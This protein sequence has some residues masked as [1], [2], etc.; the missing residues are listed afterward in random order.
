MPQAN[1]FLH[2][3]YSRSDPGDRA[4]YLSFEPGAPPLSPAWHEALRPL[5]KNLWDAGVRA[6]LLVYGSHLGADPF[7]SGRLDEVGGL[8]RGYSRGIPGLESLLAA[9]RPNDYQ[10]SQQDPACQPPYANDDAS[11]A[12]LDNLLND[13]GNFSEEYVKGLRDGL[14]QTHAMPFM[15]QRY[16]WSSLHHHPGR[17]EGALALCHE[18]N[19]LKAE[20]DLRANDRILIVAHGHAG[21]LPALLS[22]LVAPGDSSVRETVFETLAYFYEQQETPSAAVQHL[23]E[24]DRLLAENQLAAWPSLDVVTLGTPIRYGWDTDGLGKLLHVVNHRPIRQDGKRWL[25]KMELPQIVMEMPMASGGDYVHQLAVAGTD[26][27][28][29]S[30][31]EVELDQALR[32]NLEPYDGFERWLECARRVTR[33]PND[34]QCLLIDYHDAT[35]GAPDE[36]LFG[37]ACYTR[38]DALLFQTSRIVETL[39]GA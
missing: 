36:H 19:R 31:W 28:P 26:A 10:R 7:G 38:L 30:P 3:K 32:E 5:G 37:H 13:K 16:L 25:A 11:K 33:C 8:K 4:K 24:L 21:Q 15:V 17:M 1:N 39:Y 6:I 29:A 27:V 23:Q 34:G 14:S 18:L 20:K 9:L 35:G 12:K 2:A 22:N